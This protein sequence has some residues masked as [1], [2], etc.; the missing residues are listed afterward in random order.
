MSITIFDDVIDVAVIGLT[1]SGKSTFIASMI[2]RNKF[3][4]LIGKLHQND[5]GLTKVTTFYELSDCKQTVVSEVVFDLG[6]ITHGII[7]NDI[8]GMNQK[9]NSNDYK[10]FKIEPVIA[11][12][13]GYFNKSLEE[14]LNKIADKIKNDIKF[15]ISIINHSKADKL[16]RYIKLRVPASEKVLDS[17]HKHGFKSVVL[18]DTR[19]FLDAKL[20]E[21]EKKTPSLAET[22]LDGIQACILMNGQD[23]PM[24]NL[25]RDI[26]GEFVKSIFEAVPTFII[27]RSGKLAGKLEDCEDNG[28][29]VSTEV[30]NGLVK[31]KKVSSLNFNEVHKFLYS[32]DII[33]EE[34]NAS[35]QLIKAH[36]RELL[37]PEVSVLKE[38]EVDYDK[39]EYHIYEF[40]SMEVFDRLL[41][42]LSDFR[43]LLNKIVLF[44]DD[45]IKLN[46]IHDKFFNSFYESLFSRII[47]EYYDYH[48]NLDRIVRPVTKGFS[49]DNLLN[50]LVHGQLLGA[51]DGITSRSEDGSYTYGA[52][53][54]FAVTAWKTINTLI[55]DLCESQD[56]I[57]SIKKYAEMPDDIDILN[58]YTLEIQQCLKYVL[59]N[60]FTDVWA[61]FGGYSIINRYLAVKAIENSNAKWKNEYSVK[62]GEDTLNNVYLTKVRDYMNKKISNYRFD[63]WDYVR[64]SQLYQIFYNTIDEF[65]GCV[66]NNHDYVDKNSP[67]EIYS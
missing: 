11:S 35:N 8:E 12:E 52:T 37:L 16:V 30:Y 41:S 64:F 50:N 48:L 46:D 19:G 62:Y 49:K 14:N 10:Y 44:F 53:G 38:K 63:N 18:R 54:V 27:E 24:P 5:G 15:A 34:G 66:S 58:T 61:N 45:K 32:L 65:F 9:L 40:C 20:D 31:N 55:V 2:D 39:A 23:S 13:D 21:I 36:K 42:S 6:Q 17:M 1:N 56:I 29:N 47:M 51:K 43:T 26:Y 25:G 4:D 33:N 3:G 60:S 7:N 28:I 59:Q 67:T 22:G 57:N